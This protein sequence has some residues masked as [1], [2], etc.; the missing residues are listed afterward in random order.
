MSLSVK[1][2]KP[3][4]KYLDFLINLF[5]LSKKLGFYLIERFPKES[6]DK[7]D[8]TGQPL[9]DTT[10]LENRI[11]AS[12]QS[13]LQNVGVLPDGGRCEQQLSRFCS[14]NLSECR[15][16]RKMDSNHV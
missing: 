6:A 8:C 11:C 7:A 2:T 3:K 15:D 12:L 9:D 16:A 5:N 13:D 14:G 10:E 1:S 4:G